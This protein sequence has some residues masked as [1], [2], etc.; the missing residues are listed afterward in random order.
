[1]HKKSQCVNCK[2][3]VD[4]TLVRNITSAGVSNVW[5]QCEVCHK[6]AGGSAAWLPHEPIIKFGVDIDTLPVV[7][8]GRVET[9]ILCGAL[10]A[11]YHHWMPRHLAGD[12]ADLWPGAM[13]CHSHHEHW[14]RIVTPNMC[15]KTK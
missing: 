6:N 14:H 9:C 8:D 10:G 2:V 7:K 15:E 4:V 1:M 3:L 11:E 13:L 12:E 5:W